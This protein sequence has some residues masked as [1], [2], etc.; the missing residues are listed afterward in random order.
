MGRIV[1][2]RRNDER[3][4]HLLRRVSLRQLI[5]FE[6]LAHFRNFRKAAA[7]LNISQPTLS[8]QMTQLEQNL[9]LNLLDR[10]SSGAALT[11][12]GQRLQATVTDL[13]NNFTT[14]IAAMH[15]SS[16][17]RLVLAIPSY[18]SYP[19]VHALIREFQNEYPRAELQISE[20]TA[21]QMC[22]SLANGEITVAFLSIP[23]PREL[24]PDVDIR[25]IYT[26]TYQLCLAGSHP[27]AVKE[28]I[29]PEQL[30]EL[31]IILLPREQHPMHFDHQVNGFRAIGVDPVVHP[32]RITNVS[33]QIGLASTG[34]GACLVASGTLD[35]PGNMVIRPTVPG[36]AELKLAIVS[37]KQ[38][39]NPYLE[40][41]YRKAEQTF[42]RQ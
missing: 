7:D 16:P 9:E 29:L 30:K 32:A 27:L 21:Q 2:L 22:M 33:G 34:A 35:L 19:Q 11:P 1:N 18:Q 23:C 26:A 10:S 17:Q 37:R 4:L 13:L 41:F 40:R 12:C 28:E 24:P 14:S 42:A 36:L 20:M 31:P 25:I 39:F 8:Q 5:Y 15:E 3:Y 6:R 38:D